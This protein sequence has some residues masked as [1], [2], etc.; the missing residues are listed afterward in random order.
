MLDK[1]HD[2][3]ASKEHLDHLDTLFSGGE[4]TS[5]RIVQLMAHKFPTLSI[6][7]INDILFEWIL[8]Q[9]ERHHSSV[10]E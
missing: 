10:E 5:S 4:L 7:D 8:T 6:T 9:E 3:K 1:Q 2:V